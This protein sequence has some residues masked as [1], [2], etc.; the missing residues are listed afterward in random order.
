MET[1]DDHIL[2]TVGLNLCPVLHFVAG[3]VFR[4]AGYIVRGIGIRS[5]CTDSRHQFVVLVGNEI[6]GSNL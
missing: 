2:E 5:L 3:N 4:V 6:L 1:A